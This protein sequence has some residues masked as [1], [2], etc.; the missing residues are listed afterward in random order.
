MRKPRADDEPMRITVRQARP[1]DQP[2]ITALGSESADS[3]LSGVRPAS[4]AV[5]AD[6]FERLAKFCGTRE[7]TVTLIADLDGQ[8]AGFCILITDIPDEVTQQDQGF[9]AY[10]AV[11]AGARR[12]GIGRALLRAVELEARDRGL[13]HLSLMVTAGNAAARALYASGRFVEE[14]VLMTK[15]LVTAP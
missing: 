9:I 3:S 13:P 7:G 5:A 10:M 6:A 8:R 11:A 15:S 1:D 4:R 2:F 14:R 12:R